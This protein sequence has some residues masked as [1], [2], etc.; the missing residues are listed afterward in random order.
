MENKI[1]NKGLIN[2]VSKLKKDK[3][4][5]DKIT[6]PDN[7]DDMY[8]IAITISDGYTKQEFQEFL[9]YINLKIELKDEDL[10]KVSGGNKFS[11]K[12]GYFLEDTAEFIEL[13]GANILYNFTQL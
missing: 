12:L 13:G 8:N 6:E 2:L 10:E 4:L 7:I 3:S 9:N 5:I 11:T 1:E